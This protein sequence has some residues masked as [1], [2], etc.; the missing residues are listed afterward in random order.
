MKEYTLREHELVQKLHPQLDK[1]FVIKDEKSLS[2]GPPFTSMTRGSAIRDIQE[3]LSKGH[4]IW[5]RHPQDFALYEIGSYSPSTGEILL[6]D[7]KNCLGLM[8]DFKQ[9]L[10]N[11]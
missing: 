5:A 9:S 1:I 7:Q 4:A 2:Y 8:Q 6:Y 10:G 3:G 11:N